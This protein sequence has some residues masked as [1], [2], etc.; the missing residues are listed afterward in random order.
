VLYY[1]L[2][3]RLTP[4]LIVDTSSVWTRKLD[5]IACHASQISRPPG[6]A[7][8][9]IGSPDAMAAIESRDRYYGSMIGTTCGEALKSASTLGITDLIAHFRTNDFP[10]AH[11]FES[12]R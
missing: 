1:P 2:R 12:L 10:R 5:A 8:T 11:A 3:Y 9:L 7:P 4:S 6:A